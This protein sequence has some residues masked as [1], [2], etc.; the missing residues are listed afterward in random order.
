M[1]R[2][3]ADRVR[4]VW[5][6]RAELSTKMPQHSRGL[7]LSMLPTNAVGAEIGVHEG[8][9]SRRLL[10]VL[11]PRKMHLIDPWQYQRGKE[12]AEAYYGGKAKGGQTQL[13]SR[14]L[15]VLQRFQPEIQTGQVEVHRAF[16]NQVAVQ[17]ADEYFDFVYI[18]GDHRYAAVKEDLELYFKKLKV[19]GLLCGD[20]YGE[21]GW[22]KGGV[23]RAV[24]EFAS[25]NKVKIVSL[26][27]SQF[28]LE[29]T[30]PAAR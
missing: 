6:R 24:D 16:S 19:R 15:R 28:C 29:K 25:N 22:W 23:E 10:D 26:Q 9:F 8:D 13:D 12:F 14:Y 18:D 27:H 11:K 20:D 1:V 30:Q 4:L 7:L 17:F 3:L 2:T 5:P 21:F